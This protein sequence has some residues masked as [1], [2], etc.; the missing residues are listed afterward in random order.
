[1]WDV[2]KFNHLFLGCQLPLTPSLSFQFPWMSLPSLRLSLPFHF[3]LRRRIWLA[4]PKCPGLQHF[5]SHYV[6]GL[7][8]FCASIYSPCFC[9]FSRTCLSG[10]CSHLQAFLKAV[11][12]CVSLCTL[13]SKS[14]FKKALLSHATFVGLMRFHPPK[15]FVDN[16]T[17]FEKKKRYIYLF[18]VLLCWNKAWYKNH[19]ISNKLLHVWFRRIN[20]SLTLLESVTTPKSIEH[21]QIY[22]GWRRKILLLLLLS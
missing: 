16:K 12:V 17:P 6:V 5:F 19:H 13:T 22:F 7:A 15:D 8:W 20:F 2:L 21:F 10:C 18:V 9:G 1:M 14:V 3:C 11:F 4:A